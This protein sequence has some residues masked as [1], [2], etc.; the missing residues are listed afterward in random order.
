MKYPK[1]YMTGGRLV[2]LFPN[3]DIEYFTEYDLWVKSKAPK[4]QKNY[5]KDTLPCHAEYIG[6]IK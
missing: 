5:F 3:G 1:L 6:E 2:I 4:N